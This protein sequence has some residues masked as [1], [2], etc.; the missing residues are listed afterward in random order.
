[1][2]K[3]TTDNPFEVLGIAKTVTLK[4]LDRAYAQL[5]FTYHP[6]NYS[7]ES[8]KFEAEEMLYKI[9][10][11]YRSAKEII[12]SEPVEQGIFKNILKTEDKP[13]TPKAEVVIERSGGK[14][15]I[16]KSYICEGIRKKF[17]FFGEKYP[18]G[19]RTEFSGSDD[20]VYL[21]LKIKN[22]DRTFFDLRIEWISPFGE[23][24]QYITNRFDQ[25]TGSFIFYCWL[26][27]FGVKKN[28]LYGNWKVKIYFNQKE[29][30]EL[31]FKIS[32]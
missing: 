15:E 22:I 7:S 24:F 4:E 29:K 5:E 30:I 2:K 31:P 23:S 11:A 19:I 9:D 20:E 27:L 17:F 14:A 25:F 18:S 26:D 3:K 8:E 28:N 16:L 32:Q 6:D 13:V 1:M 10:C 12:K 21:Y